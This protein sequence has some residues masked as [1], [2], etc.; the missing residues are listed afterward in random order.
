MVKGNN[1][2]VA[3]QPFDVLAGCNVKSIVTVIITNDGGLLQNIS[4]F[5]NSSLCVT[6]KTIVFLCK[7]ERNEK[8]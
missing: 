6:F 5:G 4:L 3:Y 7:R 2:E 8:L 1:A